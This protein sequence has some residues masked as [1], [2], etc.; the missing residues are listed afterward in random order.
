M[1]S[2]VSQKT[3]PLSLFIKKNTL[4]IKDN[5]YYFPGTIELIFWENE[6]SRDFS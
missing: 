4:N 2:Y 5:M 3:F 6:T 1:V